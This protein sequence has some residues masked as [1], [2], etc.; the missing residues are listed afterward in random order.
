MKIKGYSSF[1]QKEQQARRFLLG[2]RQRL[3]HAWQKQTKTQKILCV[4]AAA[5]CIWIIALQVQVCQLEQTVHM[6]EVRISQLE[7]QAQKQNN[8]LYSAQKDLNDLEEKWHDLNFR[9][10]DNTWRIDAPNDKTPE[11]L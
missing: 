10:L 6:Q 11:S 2:K 3:S 8:F 9:V 1:L 5:E 4:L 7:K